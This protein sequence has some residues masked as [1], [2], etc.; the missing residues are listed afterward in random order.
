M[1]FLLQLLC[2]MR[3]Q[4][5]GRGGGG[6]RAGLHPAAGDALSRQLASSRSCNQKDGFCG[7]GSLSRLLQSR[8]L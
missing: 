3:L 2:A 7:Y 5:G 1:S 4:V 8:P 6:V